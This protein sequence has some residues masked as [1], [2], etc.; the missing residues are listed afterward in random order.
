MI[1]LFDVSCALFCLMK[2]NLQKPR[3]EVKR[4]TNKWPQYAQC[5][6]S[7]SIRLETTGRCNDR[8]YCISRPN[9]FSGSTLSQGLFVFTFGINVKQ[10]VLHSNISG[11]CGMLVPVLHV[12]VCVRRGNETQ[13]RFLKESERR[14]V[15]RGR[16][17]IQKWE[18]DKKNRNRLTNLPKFGSD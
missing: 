5:A 1:L 10:R 17:H 13:N 4:S 2:S 9:A 16:N 6:W 3:A 18:R 7:V 14:T 11:R 15:T 8:L 12:C